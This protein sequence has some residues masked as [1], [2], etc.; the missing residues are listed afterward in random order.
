ML[1]RLLCFG[2]ILSRLNRTLLHAGR[3]RVAPSTFAVAGQLHGS[4]G[5]GGELVHVDNLH[6]LHGG[7]L[8][9]GLEGG[10]IRWGHRWVNSHLTTTQRLNWCGAPRVLSSPLNMKPIT[11]TWPTSGGVWAH[12][13]QSVF[14]LA[15]GKKDKWFPG[16]CFGTTDGGE[17]L[18][19]GKLYWDE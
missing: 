4:H 3:S 7:Q 1:V 10:A 8:A 11:R 2:H 9:V 13:C 6:H 18:I 16:S 5:E 12:T 15:K 19:V 17:L 14:S